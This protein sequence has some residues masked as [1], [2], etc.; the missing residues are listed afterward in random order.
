MIKAQRTV[1][2]NSLSA[3]NI[4]WS[5]NCLNGLL[6]EGW[7]IVSFELFPPTKQA[8]AGLRINLLLDS[9]LK[10]TETEDGI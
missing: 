1:V 4:A 2:V 8:K 5:I 9:P 3:S 10:M 7:R 6:S